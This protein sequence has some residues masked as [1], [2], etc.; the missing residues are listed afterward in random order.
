MVKNPVYFFMYLTV[1]IQLQHNETH[2]KK[3]SPLFTVTTF[4]VNYLP[5]SFFLFSLHSFK[6]MLCP[7]VAF[8]VE[9]ESVEI[10]MGRHNKIEALHHICNNHYF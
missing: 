6:Q 7:F 3:H 1:L 2:K 5:F 8:L 10:Y 4:V 9:S